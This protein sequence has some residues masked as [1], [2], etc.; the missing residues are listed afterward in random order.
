LVA[1]TVDIIDTTFDKYFSIEYTLSI[2]IGM[3]SFFYFIED[4][5]SNALVLKHIRFDLDKDNSLQGKDVA[6]QKI[7]MTEKFLQLPYAHVN[8]CY[9]GNN[10]TIVPEE[11]F[12]K[13]HLKSYLSQVTRIQDDHAVAMCR[14]NN[15]DSTIVYSVE[16]VVMDVAKSYFPGAR[17]LHIISPLIM[18]AFQHTQNHTGHQVF[19]HVG[20]GILGMILFKGNALILANTYRFESNQ[21]FLYQALSIYDQFKLDPETV[22]LILTGRVQKKSE[23][24]ELMQTYIRKIEFKQSPSYYHYG[25]TFQ[26]VNF[27]YYHDLLSIKL[28][29]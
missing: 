7:L 26:D 13:H 8:I 29:V 25:P 27:H 12:N 10:F 1:N 4:A 11:I 5:H 22:P 19:I 14:L 24:Y 23:L 15:L 18:Q 16:K 17:H 9:A 20:N 2:L 21:D 3:D 6:L 28:C